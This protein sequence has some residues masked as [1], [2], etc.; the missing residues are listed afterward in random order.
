M[1]IDYERLRRDLLNYF[2]SATPYFKAAYID[3]M[4]VENASD[5]ELELIAND[6]GFDLNNYTQEEDNEYSRFTL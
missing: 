6:Y 4:R 2:G 3:V 5:Y 1:E